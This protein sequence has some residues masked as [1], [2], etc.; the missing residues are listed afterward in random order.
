MVHETVSEDL[1]DIVFKSIR[2]NSQHLSSMLRRPDRLIIMEIVDE[3]H[4]RVDPRM[5]AIV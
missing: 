4:K 3:V 2:A 1:Q 5:G